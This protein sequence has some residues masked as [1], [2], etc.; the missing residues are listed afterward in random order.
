MSPSPD[1]CSTIGLRRDRRDEVR[2]H[3]PPH[4]GVARHLRDL[5]RRRVILARLFQDLRHALVAG[6]AQEVDAVAHQPRC[7][8]SLISTSAPR[9]AFTSDSHFFVSPENT[10]ERPCA[11]T[12]N[13]SAGTTGRWS[14]SNAPISIVADRCHVRHVR[15]RRD[16]VHDALDA[17]ARQL[18]AVVREAV[19]HVGV[20]PRAKAFDDLAR[21]LRAVRSSAASS[22]RRPSSASSSG[23]AGR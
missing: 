3:E 23:R 10:T 5:E 8:A 22:H 16:L 20:Q 1:D 18:F 14:T 12:L 19:P 4:A 15:R 11:L 7:T 2:E 6:A 13:P 9:A 21:A 17:V